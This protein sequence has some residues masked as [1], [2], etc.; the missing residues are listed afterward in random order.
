M[1]SVGIMCSVKNAIIISILTKSCY[2]KNEVISMKN[3]YTVIYSPFG[4]SEF[5]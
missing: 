2:L 3:V 1:A 4:R 5:F